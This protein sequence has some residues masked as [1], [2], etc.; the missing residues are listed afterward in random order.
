MDA[1]SLRREQRAY[2]AFG[3]LFAL[4]PPARAARLA[5]IAREDEEL[6]QTLRRLLRAADDEAGIAAAERGASD[7]SLGE[8]FASAPP[9]RSGILISGRLRLLRRLGVGGMGEVYLAERTDIQQQVALKLVR[10][11]VSNPPG[12]ARHERQ[13]L[14]RLGHT[15]IAGLIDAGISDA[16]EPWFAME[17]VEGEPITDW[18]DRRRLDLRARVRLFGQ[19]CVAVQF[20]HKNLILHRDLKPSNILVN[21]QGIPK[22][23]DFGIAKLFDPEDGRETQTFA[24]TPAYAAPEQLRGEPATTASD[25]Y[26]LGLVLY[27]LAGGV[28]AQDARKAQPRRTDP[29]GLP[30]LDQ[31][32]S[33]LVVRDRSRASA[34]AQARGTGVDRLRRLLKGDLSRIAA[35]ALADDP[36]VRYASAQA[37][38]DDLERWAGGLP[39]EARQGS[40]AYR[41]EKALRRHPF[42]AV[43][44]LALSLGL[45][46]ASL[47]AFDSAHRERVQRD[48]AEQQRQVAEDQRELAE[49]QRRHADEQRRHAESLLGFMREMFRS[50][51]PGQS[52]DVTADSAA[53]MLRRAASGL[54]RRTDIDDVTRAVLLTQ[55]ADVYQDLDR[56]PLAL[57][58]AERAHALLSP[59]KDR[60]PSEY[61]LSVR[62]LAGIYGHLGRSRDVVTLVDAAMPLADKTHDGITPWRATLL[63]E[64]GQAKFVLG[65][66]S[67]ALADENA[68]LAELDEA[69]GSGGV[70]V[71]GPLLTAAVVFDASGDTRRAIE[72]NERIVALAK[73][74][75]AAVEQTALLAT[76]ANLGLAHYRLGEAQAV[77]DSAMPVIERAQT[78]FGPGHAIGRFARVMV[79]R[80]R[81][82]MGDYAGARDQIEQAR[83]QAPVSGDDSNVRV[84]TETARLRLALYSGQFPAAETQARELVE[85][86]RSSGRSD[87]LL[88]SQTRLLGEVLL[89][90]RDIAGAIEILQ[91][92]RRSV[93][94][95]ERVEMAEIED[96]LGRACLLRSDWDQARTHLHNAIALFRETQGEDKP[97]TVRSEIHLAWVEAL[98]TREVAAL[99]RLAAKRTQLVAALGGDDKPQA[100]QFDLLVD[101]LAR[102]L[103]R[104]GIDAGRRTQAEAGLARMAGRRVA[105]RF[106]GLNGF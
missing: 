25:V 72:V 97:N 32:L 52:Q 46:V 47:I 28:S 8:A 86:A 23:L 35:K 7:S 99:D 16:G 100:W 54:E 34:L 75:P 33:A 98:A 4:T 48:R 66:E 45:I 62:V 83:A 39:V 73:S 90:R 15:H 43:A 102:S 36:H 93:G 42:A 103:G 58:P 68:A 104:P 76:L 81:L 84:A 9:D 64:R 17:Y 82:A 21:A 56:M 27:E 18:C 40:Y 74:D 14:A 3:E 69:G 51:A 78:R 26:Q 85:F 57:A 53:E 65:S 11:D 20:A 30:R 95:R 71:V 79:A 29:A 6:A 38:A 89:Q 12:R 80:A 101:D 106:V 37:L 10:G 92:A 61:L 70:D 50:N 24:L 87:Q 2:A 49:E 94:A 19:I 13:I 77:L 88:V 5:E 55:I 96:S 91:R 105:P 44:I 41:F 22:L 67:E 31:A 60:H 59:Q 1:A 63:A